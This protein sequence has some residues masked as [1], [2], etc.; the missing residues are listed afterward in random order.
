MLVL[1]F[2]SF[3]FSCSA[4]QVGACCTHERCTVSRS[5]CPSSLQIRR[6]EV[7]R[8]RSFYRRVLCTSK[9]QQQQ[10]QHTFNIAYLPLRGDFDRRQNGGRP[11]SV[12]GRVNEPAIPEKKKKNNMKTAP[13]QRNRRRA[14]A[15]TTKSPH[16]L[17][18]DAE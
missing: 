16:R 10:Q 18:F 8:A 14:A 5:K 2:I 7:F 9:E 11:K 4:R 3:F 17:T 6:K 13:R 1:V 15:A 12:G